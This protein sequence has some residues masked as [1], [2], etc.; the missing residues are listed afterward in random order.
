GK[1]D[2]RLAH[3]SGYGMVAA[4]R[5]FQHPIGEWNF[6][7]VTVKGST[8][9]VELNGTIILNTDLSRVTEYMGKSPH[10]GKE[11]TSGHFGFAGHSDPVQFR[12]VSIKR[13]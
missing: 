11:R 2:P 7:E 13:L 6:Q 10:P 1:I 3:G 12:G 4:H 5:G 9:K 8:I